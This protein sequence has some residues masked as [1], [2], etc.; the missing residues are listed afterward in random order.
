MARPTKRRESRFYQAR[1]RVP[2]ELQSILGRTEFKRSLR[3]TSL[4]DVKRLHS[5][6]L[7]EF[8]RLIA[9]ARAQLNGNLRP[10]TDRE[11]SALCG[12]W[13]GRRLAEVEAEGPI[14]PKRWDLEADLLTDRI[15]RDAEDPELWGFTPSN[16]DLA[17]AEL[18]LEEHGVAAT[19]SSLAR[20]AEQLHLTKIQAARTLIRRGRGDFGPDKVPE[21]FAKEL[22]PVA[23][24]EPP[25]VSS[26]STF[27][28]L[29]R[30]WARDNGYDPDAKPVPVPYYEK[31]R[32]AARLAAFVGHEDAT[33]LAQFE[34][35]LLIE[36]TNSGLARAK[37]AGTT[38]GRPTALDVQQ[39]A[40][41]REA[42]QAGASVSAVAKQFDT[43]RQTIMRVR[44]A[45]A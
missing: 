35:D 9:V 33:R 3:A 22:P 8:D 20:L 28:D 6:A 16:R 2:R 1:K 32:T 29:V 36:R 24:A 44:D 18:F 5:E 4:V 26:G 14:D 45:V 38:L 10:L 31:H 7:A 21:R 13:Y 19:A 42:L 34:R 27:S 37:A 17:E 23:P 39:Q 43:S 41:V 11:I 40:A 30:G 12:V 15:H 25:E